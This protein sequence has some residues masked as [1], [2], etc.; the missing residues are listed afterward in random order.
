MQ[1]Q[2]MQKFLIIFKFND[3]VKKVLSNVTGS[4]IKSGDEAKKLCSQQLTSGVLWVKEEKALIDLGVDKVLETG[5][6][7]VLG[8][9]W[10]AVGGDIKCLPA[11]T[12]EAIDAL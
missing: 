3:P 2:N 11:G 9:L 1:K 5:P 12:L 10:K 8:G 4:E 7:S 6:G